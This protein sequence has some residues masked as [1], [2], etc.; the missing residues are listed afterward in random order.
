MYNFIKCFLDITFAVFFLAI[1]FPFILIVS[2]LIKMDS[3]GPVLFVQKRAGHN[4]ILFTI[5]KFRTMKLETPNLP[6]DTLGDP[7]MYLTRLGKILR[8]TS[9][10]ELPQLLNILLGEM[11]FI[12]PRPALY[13][14]NELI[15]ERNKLGINQIKPGL[16]GYAQV[17]GRDF[18]TD[19]QKVAFDK[20]YMEN[21]SLILDL[22]I[23]F[24]TVI[25]VTRAENIKG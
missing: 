9:L 14:Q 15:E 11:S 8:K 21:L 22:K 19:K 10:D 6:T 3:K 18:I 17:M 7:E 5:Y 13:N 12:G 20:Y 2:F 1:L 23:L 25:K 24:M 16:T 4:G